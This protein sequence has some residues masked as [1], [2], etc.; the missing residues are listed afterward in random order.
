MEGRME[1]TRKRHTIEKSEIVGH[2]DLLKG[3]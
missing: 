1:G 3:R 2:L